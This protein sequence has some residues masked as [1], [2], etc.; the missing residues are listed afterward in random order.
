MPL[1]DVRWI[2]D[3]VETASLPSRFLAS[4]LGG[5][6][7]FAVLLATI[8]LYGVVA[9]GVSRRRRDIAIR[10]ALGADRTRVLR[11]F[12]AQGMRLITVGVIAGLGGGF[13]LSNLLRSQLYGVSTTDPLSYLLVALVLVVAALAATWLPARRATRTDPIRELHSG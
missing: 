4:L 13:A 5:F 8:G 1:N 7:T 6:A 9:Y 11:M 2:E 12:L 10:M 3:D